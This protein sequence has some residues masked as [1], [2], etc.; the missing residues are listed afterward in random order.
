MSEVINEFSKIAEYQTNIQKSTVFLNASN[1]QSESE[2]K[3]TISF[4]INL[5]E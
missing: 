5:I 2:I 3:K 1:E 4:T